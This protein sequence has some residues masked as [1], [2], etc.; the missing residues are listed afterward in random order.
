[1]R[2]LVLLLLVG[3]GSSE[4]AAHV[5]VTVDGRSVRIDGATALRGVQLELTWDEGLHVSAISAGADAARLDL[6]RV[7]LGDD[8]KSARVLL[9]DTRKVALPA[10]GE[11]LHVVAE[12]DGA[13]H[14]GRIITVAP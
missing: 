1:M 3:C 7:H 12:G 13:L 8:G 5:D 10:H 9:S 11:L 2:W 14:L 6:V 4:P